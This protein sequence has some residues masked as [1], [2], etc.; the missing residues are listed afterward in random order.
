MPG[1]WYAQEMRRFKPKVTPELL[2]SYME[3]ML[4]YLVK[5]LGGGIHI[6]PCNLENSTYDLLQTVLRKNFYF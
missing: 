3:L 6:L 2:T 1:V 4:G 5:D